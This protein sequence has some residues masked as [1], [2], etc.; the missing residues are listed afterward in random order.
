MILSHFLAPCFFDS[1]DPRARL[2]PQCPI[3][4]IGFTRSIDLLLGAL[5]LGLHFSNPFPEIVFKAVK[6]IFN[7]GPGF[8]DERPRHVDPFPDLWLIHRE[9]IDSLS[10]VAAKISGG[11]TD[12]FQSVKKRHLG[13]QSIC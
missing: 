11:F 3:V 12:T 6:S 10:G 13:P 4:I 5:S 7:I 8:L 9:V 2:N 1:I